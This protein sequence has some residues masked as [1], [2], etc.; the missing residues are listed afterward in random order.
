[1]IK[2]I[3]IKKFCT[4]TGYTVQ[5]VNSKISRGDWV[6]DKEYIKAPDGRILID[7]NGFHEWAQKKNIQESGQEAKVQSQSP[8]ITK[9]R[10]VVSALNSTPPPLT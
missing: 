4:E 1:M 8:S 5:A 2:L 7:I 10:N 9:A 3:T 6:R